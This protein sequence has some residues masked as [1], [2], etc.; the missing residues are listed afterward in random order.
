MVDVDT[1]MTTRSEQGWNSTS[2]E[3]VRGAMRF[4]EFDGDD[5]EVLL[6]G[7]DLRVTKELLHLAHFGAV[8]EHVDGA[9]VTQHVGRDVLQD[10]HAAHC[11][12]DG[13]VPCPAQRWIRPP[14]GARTNDRTVG[15]RN[16]RSAP[17]QA[18]RLPAALSLTFS[19]RLASGAS[20][21]PLARW[22]FT[23]TPTASHRSRGSPCL[24]RPR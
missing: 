1:L 17:R 13:A 21:G 11:Q 20:R 2:I 3:G 8:L 7:R 16:D 10:R 12:D 23:G 24:R 6:R 14:D 5:V 4:L 19:R 9:G 18:R 15:R 22:F